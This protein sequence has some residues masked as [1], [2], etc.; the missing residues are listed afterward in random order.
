MPNKLLIY[1]A[2]LDHFFPGNRI[3]VPLGIGSIK[4]Y[5]ISQF[6]EKLDI[7]LFK[8]PEKLMK[9]IKKTPPDILGCSFY[10]WNSNLT[11]KAIECCNKIS[12]ST[13]TVI[14]GPNVSRI[15]DRY[16]ELLQKNPSLDIIVLDQ[17]EKTFALIVERIL[18]KGPNRKDIFSESMPGCAIR[19]KGTGQIIRGKIVDDISGLNKMP[20]PYLMGYLDSFIE[21]G[22][23]PT[24]ETV[25]GCPHSCT[26]CGGGDKFVNKLIVKDEEIVYKELQ[27]LLKHSKAREID[28]IDTNFGVMGERD[29][30]IIT[31]INEL[32]KKHNFPFI[33][34][35]A[36]TKDQRKTTIE[37]LKKIA[38]NT[39]FMC[40]GIQTLTPEVLKDC[41]RKNVPI[42]TMKKLIGMAKK[43]NIPVH[44]D[45]I[46]G[47]PGETKSSFIKTMAELR[48]MGIETLE[49]YQLR[50]LRGTQIS[51]KEREKYKYKTK[52]RPINN[53]FGEYELLPGEK[54]VRVIELEEIA[55]ENSTFNFDDYLAIRELGFMT[56]LLTGYGTFADT[57]AFVLSKGMNI[58]DIMQFIQ[59]NKHQYPML[60][61]LFK[62]YREYSE[63]E[64]FPTEEDF[65]E[66]IV[67]DD[68][69][70]K[71]L[72]LSG[73]NYFKI[74]IGFVGYCLF[75]NVEL[76][77]SISELIKKYAKQKLTNEEIK[78]L[79][80]IIKHDRIHWVI[81]DKI[82]GK[83]KPSDIKENIFFDE[84]FDYEKWK[85]DGAIGSL[86]DYKLDSPIRQ[87]YFIKKYEDLLQTI[88]KVNDLSSYNF[89]ERVVSQA[90][91]VSMK[92]FGRNAY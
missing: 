3:S 4:S 50:M 87:V 81:Q 33:A 22:Y 42:D 47:L 37:I 75:H 71:N 31:Y 20:S 36:S 92:R 43:M 18:E 88:N 6:G 8:H 84:Y 13:I 77:D 63:K 62:E 30:R 39:G 27:Y 56:N 83:L 16:K 61:E 34:G 82:E 67:N 49:T 91:V 64:F 80:Q 23:L 29:L 73:G 58:I 9:E 11:L 41:N 52:F 53:R 78:A 24:F 51:E 45:T 5:A 66:R 44:V 14:G 28:L 40:F 2:D 86:D 12:P 65:I 74:N 54:P 72:M 89:Y 25:R 1:L 19:L 79:D 90:P 68:K 85:L 26:Y 38:E 59:Q 70:W 55:V 15:S 60:T 69:Q 76:L 21:E 10:M 57:M 48:S 7:K 46:F 35:F 32:Y 17:G